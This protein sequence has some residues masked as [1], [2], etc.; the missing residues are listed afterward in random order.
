[1]TNEE[2]NARLRSLVKNERRITKEILELVLIAMERRAFR[3]FGYSSLF[4]WLTRGFGYSPAAAMRRIEAARLLRAVPEAKEKIE[5][6]KLNLS[7]LSK[8]QSAIKAQEKLGSVTV[9]EKREAL[10]EVE[11]LSFTEAERKI[12]ELFPATKSKVHQEKRTVVD[13]NTTRHA[14][15][16]PKEA[17]ENLRRAKELLSHQF[18]SASD[19]EI[20]A[21]ALEFLLE[22]KDPLRRARSVSEPTSLVG[23]KREALQKGEGRC[24]YVNPQTK[25]R[26]TSRYQIQVD[27]IRPKALG[28]SDELA[29]FRLLCRQHNLLEAEKYFGEKTSRHRRR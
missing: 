27:H 1:M 22:K 13:E 11:N 24:S 3:G 14:M 6:G 7:T 25:E 4:D 19:A 16:L 21:Y 9:E 26:C 18:P 17:S 28:G 10:K 15:N 8:V 23:K 29:N 12:A 20:I 2:L 5:A